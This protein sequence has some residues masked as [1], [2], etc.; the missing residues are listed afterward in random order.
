MANSPRNR[1]SKGAASRSGDTAGAG[2]AQPMRRAVPMGT[3]S[4]VERPAGSV[5]EP[6][7]GPSPHRLGPERF[8]PPP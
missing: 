3:V 2:R 4:S 6:H 1:D 8:V 7:G 5:H